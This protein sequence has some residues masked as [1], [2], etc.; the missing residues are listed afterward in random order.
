MAPFIE[1]FADYGGFWLALLG[2]VTWIAYARLNAIQDESTRWLEALS[3]PWVMKTAVL[4]ALAAW[5][6]SF[7]VLF[8]GKAYLRGA[9]TLAELSTILLVL[10]L[11][12]VGLAWRAIPTGT[13]FHPWLTYALVLA[14]LLS[15]GPLL[16]DAPEE[17]L[18]QQSEDNDRR[19][20]AYVQGR[21]AHLDCFKA[22]GEPARRTGDGT[23]EALTA[24]AVIAFQM[25]NDLL[26]DP[27]LDEPGTVRPDQ[28]F[29]LLA[30]PFPYLFGPEPCRVTS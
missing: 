3:Q 28:E 20:V 30:R 8:L 22:A 12:L 18:S 25:A 9:A 21:L 27:K 23:F 1:A 15:S 17:V 4:L 5:L 24:S 7:G 2:A 19:A 10:V 29:R 14:L 26:Q 16:A 11:L 6:W 13:R